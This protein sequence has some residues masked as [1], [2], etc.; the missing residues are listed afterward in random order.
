MSPPIL[1]GYD[2]RSEDHAPVRFGMVVA[3]F[4]GAP[5]VVGIVE[6][7][8][9]V[10]ALSAGEQ[11]PY[12]VGM[13]LDDDLLDD[14]AQAVE[15]VETEVRA[16]GVHVDCIRL[17]SSGA[18]KAL[19]EEAEGRA[20]ALLVVGSS[21]RADSGR[22]KLGSTAA[23]LI[24][25]AP[26]PISVVPRDWMADGDVATIGVAYADSE[27]GRA[28]LHAAHTLASRGGATLRVIGVVRE[29]LPIALEAEAP[30]EGRRGKTVEDAEGEHM[31]A[32]RRR[33]QA[34]VEA[35]GAGP[36][37]EVDVMGGDPADALIHVSAHLDLL[38]CGSRGYGP[39]RAVVLGSVSSRVAD[40]AHCP[41]LVLPRG[42]RAAL[43]ALVERAPSAA[44]R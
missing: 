33:I 21:R 23:R 13:H 34:D 41:V 38:V 44:A 28:A 43:D 26:C 29:S 40:E 36:E 27:E 25:G 9:S 32:L 17:P 2:P 14:C 11:Q 18:A 42:V 22:V 37:V 3:R 20:A 1:V 8:A 15:D 39:L 16:F 24:H 31:L 7:G 10:I 6:S 4:T 5:L 30:A 19:H 12:A 35:L